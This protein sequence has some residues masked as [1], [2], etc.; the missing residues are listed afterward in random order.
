MCSQRQ[1]THVK[2][3]G[4]THMCSKRRVTH[5][6]HKA[7]N[8][9]VAKARHSLQPLHLL[10][11]PHMTCRQACRPLGCHSLS[12]DCHDRA[13]HC[14]LCHSREEHAVSV[15]PHLLRMASGHLRT[16]W[17]VRLDCCL[18]CHP[19]DPLYGESC[20]STPLQFTSCTHLLN[21]IQVLLVCCDASMF[22]LYRKCI[23]RAY[24]CLVSR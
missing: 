14:V 1:P 22:D 4:S 11:V 20:P 12:A 17:A 23:A 10:I 6:K 16:L 24:A 19:D 9:H 18:C 13:R 3:K 8:T 5:V 2:A 7:A 21:C 15:S